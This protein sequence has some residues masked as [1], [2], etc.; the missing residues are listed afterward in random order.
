MAKSKE[1]APQTAVEEYRLAVAANPTSAEAQAN[2]GWGYYGEDKW[3]E[4]LKAFAEALKLEPD[5]VDA[6]YGLALTRKCAGAK[7][8]AVNSFNAA[9]ALLPKLQDQMRGNV[10]KRLTYGHINMIQSGDWKLSS[11]LGNE[12]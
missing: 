11:I 5:S 4:A 3:D 7:V 8:E 12:S 9:L 6:L 10:L 1:V 2:L